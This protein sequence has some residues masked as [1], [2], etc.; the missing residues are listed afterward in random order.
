METAREKSLAKMHLLTFPIAPQKYGISTDPTLGD[1]RE[2]FTFWGRDRGHAFIMITVNNT[3]SLLD[4][5][6]NLA[7]EWLGK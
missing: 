7:K 6:V 2:E 4:A 3:F 1:G 5:M